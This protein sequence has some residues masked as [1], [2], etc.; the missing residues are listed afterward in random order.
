MR[1]FESKMFWASAPLLI[2]FCFVAFLRFKM[3][4]NSYT[5]YNFRIRSLRKSSGLPLCTFAFEE[6]QT[7]PFVQK[8]PFLIT[9]W[10]DVHFFATAQTPWPSIQWTLLKP[11]NRSFGFAQSSPLSV[12]MWQW[13]LEVLAERRIRQESSHMGPHLSNFLQDAFW[14]C[15]VFAVE[16]HLMK[17]CILES[18]SI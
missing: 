3:I 13:L 18:G 16:G 6:L 12:A 9:P 14:G 4:G 8:P 5:A 1:N 15:E 17:K 7:Y 10:L 11:T 2:Y